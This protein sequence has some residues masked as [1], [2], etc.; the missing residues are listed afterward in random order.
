MGNPSTEGHSRSE[1]KFMQIFHLGLHKTGTTSLQKNLFAT[2]KTPYHGLHGPSWDALRQPWLDFF[3]GKCPAPLSENTDFVYSYEA[4][5]LR[6]GGLSG[7]EQVA[8]Q[9]AMNFSNPKVLISIREPSALLV[10]A[11][12]QSL[13]LRRSSLGFRNQEPVFRRSVRFMYFEEWWDKLDGS[14][15]I[16]LAGLMDYPKVKAALAKWI[17]P[18][19]IAFLKLEDMAKS[20]P[21]YYGKLIEL[22]FEPAAVENFLH[23]PPENTGEDKKLQKELRLMFPLGRLLAGSGLSR[24]IGLALKSTG[25]F[26]PAEKVFYSGKALA[27]SKIDMQLLADIRDKYKTGFESLT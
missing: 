20:A 14:K 7:I 11:Y 16:S 25:L 13:R 22:G 5:L 3:N 12:F 21:T 1:S 26:R 27:K 24:P 6:C 19:R 4:T 9:I 17:S 2:G 18:E 23:T 15:N 8:R 10:S